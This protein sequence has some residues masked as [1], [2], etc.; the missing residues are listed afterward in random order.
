M[1]HSHFL[2]STNFSIWDFLRF[3]LVAGYRVAY[4][5][6]IQSHLS[7]RHYIMLLFL[8]EISGKNLAIFFVYLVYL[9]Y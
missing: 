1:L 3:C 4:S 9:Y 8:G 5:N 2:V 6:V 7:S